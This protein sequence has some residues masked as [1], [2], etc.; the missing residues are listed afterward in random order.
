MAAAVLLLMLVPAFASDR[1]RCRWVIDGDTFVAEGVGK[2]RLIGVDAPELGRDGKKDEPGAEKAK[3]FLIEVIGGRTVLLDYDEERF[4]KYGR[5]L[6]YVTTEKG[7]SVNEELLKRG[8]AQP[9]R[10]F[11]YKMREEYLRLMPGAG[12]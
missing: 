6:A 8:L 9:I 5:T 2:V 3:R 10:H 1:V 12:K 11:R 4:D 7:L